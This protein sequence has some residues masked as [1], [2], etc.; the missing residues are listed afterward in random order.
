MNSLE[1]RKYQSLIFQAFFARRHRVHFSPQSHATA[2]ALYCTTF[3][4]LGALAGKM[5]KQAISDCEWQKGMKNDKKKWQKC[6]PLS[7]PIKNAV[8]FCGK[9]LV[10]CCTISHHNLLAP[11]VPALCATFFGH[12]LLARWHN[13]AKKE[14]DER[15]ALAIIYCT[16]F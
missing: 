3:F 12:G 6:H 13:G 14:R 8:I 10:W 1:K 7:S 11:I 4:L 15:P 16:V 2:F 5:V 9:C